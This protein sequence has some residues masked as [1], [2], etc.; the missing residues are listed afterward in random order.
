MVHPDRPW[1]RIWD[2]L[3][4]LCTTYF[5]VEVPLRI[6]FHY[7]VDQEIVFYERIFQILFSI[8]IL[9]NFR[10]GFFEE[11]TLVMNHH[12]VARK[13]FKSWFFVDFLSAFP[14]DVFG[15]FFYEYF[16]VT[17]TLR[18]LRI[19]RAV[20]VFE[21]FKS[22]RLLAMGGNEEFQYRVLEVIN[23]VTFRLVFFIYWTSLFAHWVACGWIK[24]TPEFLK[25]SDII[26]RYIRSLYW[27]VTTLTTI[28]Y[29]DIT[30]RTNTQTIY[31]MF[32][33]IIGVGIY[34]YVVGNI[35]SLLSNVDI[36]RIKFQEKL[37]TIN[38]FL[39]YKKIPADLSNRIRSYYINL[40]ENR[41]GIDERDIWEELPSAMK[42][43][44]SLFLHAK[45]ISV[46]PFFRDA[47]EELKREIVQQLKPIAFMRGDLIFR[48][49][50]VPHNMYF[51]AKGSVDIIKESS[52]TVLDSLHEGNFFGEMALIDDRLRS[53]SVRA[54]TFCE[55][56]VLSR[57]SF[58][59]I[60]S[61]HPQFAKKI[62]QIAMSRKKQS[63][64]T[65]IETPA[66]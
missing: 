21:L 57:E 31:T 30:P 4:F 44:V 8:D 17:D 34:G 36:S 38:S 15:G 14:F 13:Y 54:R 52:G 58:R 16:G 2:L 7:K 61:H 11:R 37:D 63:K 59:E 46:V 12:Q 48:E 53:A 62:R 25:D 29:G 56:Y 26:T 64:Q 39:R 10:T 28:G 9:L 60:L 3:I 42:I 32:V 18:I 51:I 47:T 35:A 43:E 66:R 41:H 23:P 49:G 33:M 50:D 55:T 27:S 5:A 45:L 6:V 1:K 40:W 24:L 65:G 20:K 22:L 19:L